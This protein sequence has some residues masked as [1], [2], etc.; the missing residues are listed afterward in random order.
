MLVIARDFDILD[1]DDDDDDLDYDVTD[2]IRRSHRRNTKDSSDTIKLLFHAGKPQVFEKIYIW[3]KIIKD[4]AKMWPWSWSKYTTN[5]HGFFRIY[6]HLKVHG[7][8]LPTQFY[9][10]F[11]TV[12]Y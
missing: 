3:E 1:D 4:V 8:N 6:I 9:K 10:G 11:N 5:K 12:I 2:D 7:I